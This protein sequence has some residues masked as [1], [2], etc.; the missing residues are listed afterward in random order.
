MGIASNS[1]HVR[2]SWQHL[3]PSELAEMCSALPPQKAS[4]WLAQLRFRVKLSE[5]AGSG[6]RLA[7]TKIRGRTV[8]HQLRD[9]EMLTDALM[10]RFEAHLGD[11]LYHPTRD[12]LNTLI[13]AL[14]AE[15]MSVGAL[16]LVLSVVVDLDRRAKNE[17]MSVLLEDPRF[18]LP[19]WSQ[20]AASFRYEPTTVEPDCD[21]PFHAA[22]H[23][24]AAPLVGE[25]LFIHT[26]GD[27]SEWEPL[28][29]GLQVL[30]ESF[31]TAK[32]ALAAMHQDVRSG[33]PPSE[34]QLAQLAELRRSF[35]TLSDA[36]IGFSS[37]EGV[38][39]EELTDLDSLGRAAERLQEARNDRELLTR[40]AAAL[41][42]VG[43]GDVS[44]LLSELHRLALSIGSAP[45]STLMA[46]VALCDLV[47]LVAE[48]GDKEQIDFAAEKFS[49]ELPALKRLAYRALLGMLRFDPAADDTSLEEPSDVVG[50]RGGA[51]DAAASPQTGVSGPSEPRTG[52]GLRSDL[53][54]D[55]FRRPPP[56]PPAPPIPAPLVFDPTRGTSRQEPFIDRGP[57]V[58][59]P[60]YP[61]PVSDGPGLPPDVAKIGGVPGTLRRARSAPQPFLE[62]NENPSVEITERPPDPIVLNDHHPDD[63]RPAS[64]TGGI[65]E[66]TF[67]GELAWAIEMGEFALAA[68]ITK[69]VGGSRLLETTLELAAL[70]RASWSE[71]SDTSARSSIAL[72]ELPIE[73]LSAC[74][75]AR[76]LACVAAA[77]VALVA[78]YSNAT[79]FLRKSVEHYHFSSATQELFT[80]IL[81]SAESGLLPLGDVLVDSTDDP[82]ILAERARI[83]LR[84]GPERGSIYQLAAAVWRS[85]LQPNGELF[86]LLGPVASDNRAQAARV[87]ARALELQ[88]PRAIDRL[89]D[90]TATRLRPQKKSRIESRARQLLITRAEET[91]Q[92]ARNWAIAVALDKAQGSPQKTL[93]A[94]LRALL[95]E[96]AS[97]IEARLMPSVSGDVPFG[98]AVARGAARML[99]EAAP[100]ARSAAGEQAW[101]A[102]DVIL[103]PA[104]VAFEVELVNGQTTGS[105]PVAPFVSIAGGRDWKE[106]LRGRCQLGDFDLA[107]RLLNLHARG[108]EQYQDLA[109]EMEIQLADERA[110]T[111]RVGEHCRIELETAHR[112]GLVDAPTYD[113]LDADLAHARASERK[114]LSM[115]RRELTEVATKIA[116]AQGAALRAVR[117]ELE[118]SDIDQEPRARITDLIEEKEVATARAYLDLARRKVALPTRENPPIQLESIFPSMLDRLADVVING[119]IAHE[120]AQGG[121]VGP[122]SWQEVPSQHR[123]TVRNAFLS[124]LELAIKRDP[125]SHLQENIR[126]VAAV[127]GIDQVDNIRPEELRP[128][129]VQPRRWVEFS[130]RANRRA[131][132]PQFGT[133]L[134]DRYQFLLCWD[135]A[136][137]RNVR[138][139]VNE[140]E[141]TGGVFVLYFGLAQLSFRQHLA[142]LGRRPGSSRPIALIDDAT[143]LNCSTL[144]TP[145][146]EHTMR[147]CLPF[148]PLNPYKPFGG[149][150]VPLEMFYGRRSEVARV[151]DHDGPSIVYGGRQL[152]KSAIL[153]AVERQ[154]GTSSARRALYVDLAGHEIRPDTIDD[155]WRLVDDGLTRI[156]IP[157]GEATK[158][159]VLAER[160]LRRIQVWLD[161]DPQRELLLLVDEVDRFLNSDDRA[162]P[163]Q[164]FVNIWRL[165]RLRDDTQHRFKPVFTGLHDVAR[166]RSRT[167]PPFAHLESM[168]VGPM[169]P[170]EAFDLID[171][172]LE[173]LGLRAEIAAVNR[174]LAYTHFNP[175]LI[176]LFCR[177]LVTKLDDRPRQGRVIPYPVTTEDIER[178]HAVVDLTNRLRERFLATLH[179]D[180]RFLVIVLGLALEADGASKPVLLSPYE[181]RRNCETYWP[182]GFAETTYDAF[183]GLIEELVEFGVLRQQDGQFG[184][185]GPHVRLMLGSPDEI[186]QT[187][188]KTDDLEVLT[189]TSTAG[190]RSA[191]DSERYLRSPLTSSQIG[192]LRLPGK[193]SIVLGT[194]AL[195][196]NRVLEA[197]ESTTRQQEGI[198]F[199]RVVNRDS[200]WQ[201]LDAEEATGTIVGLDARAGGVELLEEIAEGWHRHHG[202]AKRGLLIVEWRPALGVVRVGPDAQLIVLEKWRRHAIF[203]ALAELSEVPPSPDQVRKAIEATGNWPS[204][205]ERLLARTV[206]SS[207]ETALEEIARVLSTPA[208]ASEFLASTGLT[209]G[210]DIDQALRALAE[211]GA[212]GLAPDDL[213]V[214]VDVVDPDE[215]SQILRFLGLATVT[216]RGALV[217]D[218][219][220]ARSMKILSGEAL[221][222]TD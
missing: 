179:L 17:A 35:V 182:S 67:P 113:A 201:A 105:V 186:E 117:D 216:D 140:R 120:I 145:N 217:A 168:V 173:A 108:S 30:A 200:F 81:H 99:A 76:V 19:E 107:E 189:D 214:L 149:G 1:L 25:E 95:E 90:A 160:V 61:P 36:F 59:N 22:A 207:L 86:A 195:L 138:E 38:E 2:A 102:D 12:E 169:V 176:Q 48:G 158:L 4:A 68:W 27:F 7:L 16:R 34:D 104:L 187:L 72:G 146:Y 98:A 183:R 79:G 139:W 73:E 143:F 94:S 40:A 64:S 57:D 92:L 165:K 211:F 206:E 88:D 23:N 91:A 109:S 221:R 132:V 28:S 180:H 188:D 78:P 66:I 144:P 185:S 50:A 77:K 6:G 133:E 184:I 124:W 172:P 101:S 14:L 103:E 199:V 204:L 152:G 74:P 215:T 126:N 163:A 142:D 219:V 29:T 148:C 41:T 155:F 123:P 97:G 128:T 55:A 192:L 193:L 202:P 198:Q 112:L 170:Q 171:K 137:E 47:S 75:P 87:G 89:I 71:S 181:I 56:E 9:A 111:A 208:G 8:Q 15:A 222:A 80:A 118:N 162:D 119:T 51:R 20:E 62:P 147:L 32:D 191:I 190:A 131:P 13:D 18:R 178:V 46:L 136:S 60:T 106:G 45:R 44:D 49:E 31:V 151:L 52:E 210:T 3:A 33:R 218:P 110:A 63:G 58:G 21:C 39:L 175:G 100:G 93:L 159:R 37:D 212:D 24:P 194:P 154:V 135:H 115:L 205:V 54:S 174:I 157:V 96:G 130:G 82:S 69:A 84:A 167:N 83:A 26:A 114:D 85:W 5:L 203:L 197:L 153:R 10:S 43:P 156:Q 177:E 42:I 11:H 53:A 150:L 220:V 122:L 125:S 116:M 127:L 129:R 65:S 141:G 161:E 121:D 70:A 209:P 196:V 166:F 164:S 213:G 134:Q